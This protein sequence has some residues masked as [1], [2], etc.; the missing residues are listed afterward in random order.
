MLLN[1]I[2][3]NYFPQLILNVNCQAELSEMISCFIL[4]DHD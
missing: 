3:N 2:K 1:F 4:H